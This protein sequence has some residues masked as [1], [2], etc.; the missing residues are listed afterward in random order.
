MRLVRF[1]SWALVLGAGA[2]AAAIYWPDQAERI[3]PGAGARA[4]ALRAALPPGLAG[5]LGLA[6]P[7]K[8]A[9]SQAPAAGGQRPPASVVLAEVVRKAAPVRFD[10]IGTVQP[11]ASVVLR[12]RV[13][14]QIVEVLVADGASV[15]A[16]D[17]IAR[18][19]SRQ[20]EAQ[21]KQ[22]EAALAKDLAALEQAQRDSARL[23]DLLTRGATTQLAVDNSKTAVQ[24]Q[25]ALV[26]SDR[27]AL[28]NLRVQLTYY[29]LK[30]PISGRLGVLAQKTGAVAR[31]G[32]AAGALG[33]I[34]QMSP[35]YVA[36]SLPQR[37]L[38]E[39]REAMKAGDARAMA[40]PQGSSVAAAG[41][42]AVIDNAIDTATGTITARAVFDNADEGLWPGQFCNVRI[43]LRTEE[44]AVTVPRLAVQTGQTG[45]F[46]FVADGDR[47]RQRPV[48]VARILDDD[49]VIASGLQP[50]EKVVV[51]GQSM[52]FPNAQFV[53]RPK[54]GA[55]QAAPGAPQAAKDG[56][57]PQPAAAAPASKT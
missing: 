37:L 5:P 7:A 40:T 6:P 25:L 45:A 50:G 15:K 38:P 4:L 24:T 48:V 49:A 28:D 19:D 39:L 12:P 17:V 53:V 22:A 32:E 41:K 36:F 3:A 27:A 11:A 33:A 54:A 9:A 47:A 14:S 52:L 26:A 34:N 57:A 16:G 31:Q 56:A 43:V 1:F 13:D 46:V 55:P 20:I 8:P 51:D 21:I 35:I 30:A 10:A 29:T 2:T 42:V 18:L 23:T 44:N